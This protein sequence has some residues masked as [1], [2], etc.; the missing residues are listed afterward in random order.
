V[1][2]EKIPRERER[3]DVTSTSDKLFTSPTVGHDSQSSFN[4]KSGN[5]SF[6]I[7]RKTLQGNNDTHL[8]NQSNN[9]TLTPEQKR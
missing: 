6:A 9:F 1:G 3:K 2:R 5:H 7:T 8:V 4:R